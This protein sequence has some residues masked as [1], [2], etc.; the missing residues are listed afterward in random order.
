[1]NILGL[2]RIVLFAALLFTPLAQAE[3]GMPSAGTP[4][5]WPRILPCREFARLR[6]LVLVPMGEMNKVV[7]RSP[8]EVVWTTKMGS[9]LRFHGGFDGPD[10][11]AERISIDKTFPARQLSAITVTGYSK[12][13]EIA[14]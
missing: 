8:K 12:R 9:S 13:T 6:F 10:L 4:T 7:D 3:Q 5:P 1:M 14:I 11:V 2:S